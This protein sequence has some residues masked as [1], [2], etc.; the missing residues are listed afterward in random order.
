[1]HPEIE[2]LVKYALVNGEL[3]EKKRAVIMRKAESLGL[4]LDEVELFLNGELERLVN[5]EI[6]KV[7]LILM[8][9]SNPFLRYSLY[10]F[11]ICLAFSLIIVLITKIFLS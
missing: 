11:L 10:F 8:I 6:V 3:T 5:G 4:D 2:K 9:M 7:N 1:M